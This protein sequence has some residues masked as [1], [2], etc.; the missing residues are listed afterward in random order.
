MCGIICLTQPAVSFIQTYTSYGINLFIILVLPS[1][2]LG[3]S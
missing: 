1:H 3:T 2:L